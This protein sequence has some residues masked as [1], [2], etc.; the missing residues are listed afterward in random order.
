MLCVRM[1]LAAVDRSTQK[2]D[3]LARLLAGHARAHTEP[4]FSDARAAAKP[5]LEAG[6]NALGYEAFLVT[7][8]SRLLAEGE[9]DLFGLGETLE[10]AR[11]LTG[12]LPMSVA[13]RLV[14]DPEIATLPHDQAAEA[15]LDLI[16]ALAPVRKVWLWTSDP[17][18]GSHWVRPGGEFGVAPIMCWHRPCAAIVWL[19]EP[20]GETECSALA[21]RAATLLGPAFERASLTET[22]V[23]RS[24]ALL[25][26]S[27][28]RLTRLG[29]DLHD[30]ALQDVALLSGELEGVRDRVAEALGPSPLGHELAAKLDDLAA[31]VS[32]LDND[33]REVAMSIDSPGALKRPF[34]DIVNSCARAFSTR[35]SIE[36]YVELAGD[37]TVLTDS[38]RIALMRIVQ[39]SL[40]NARDHSHAT[41]VRVVIRVHRSYVEATIED[42]GRG[43]RVEDA[44]TDAAR[45]GR[46]GLLGMMERV[47]MLGGVCDV[48]SHPGVGTTVSVTIARW[49]STAS[50]TVV[51]A[52]AAVAQTA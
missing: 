6:E 32:F 36:P 26:S 17:N 2:L 30:G 14:S 15:C 44:L 1:H 52:N 25:L 7:A 20:G 18:E 51:E 29:F 9:A 10:H 40:T 21:K 8:L 42:N 37:F 11:E 47:R 46:M 48:S 13:Q 12:A 19:P 41:E 22:N 33:L 43:F 24:E 35:T 49:V 5:L 50:E 27:E 39:E 31:L 4:I 28:R 16:Q 45:R 3:E 38:Q 34:K 23:E